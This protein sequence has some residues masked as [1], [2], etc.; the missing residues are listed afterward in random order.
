MKYKICSKCKKS[1]SVDRFYGDKSR[2]DGL[3][4]MCIKCLLLE[5]R[6][7]REDTEYSRG[8]NAKECDR[9]FRAKLQETSDMAIARRMHKR[10]MC[11]K[12][13]YGIDVTRYNEILDSQGGVCAICGLEETV[14]DTRYNTTRHLAVDHCHKTGVVRGL[15]CNSCNPLIGN[16]RDSV[17]IL[18]NAITYLRKNINE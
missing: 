5:Q 1:L 9:V 12:V 8:R 7:K 13:K 2:K 10:N 15:L 3:R 11:L 4:H 18:T 6:K 16:A 14:I 17:K